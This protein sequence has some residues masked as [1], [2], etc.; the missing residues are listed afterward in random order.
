MPPKGRRL[1]TEKR[2]QSCRPAGAFHYRKQFEL[3][4]LDIDKEA[5]FYR[6]SSKNRQTQNNQISVILLM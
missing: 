6:F 2:S 5:F 1:N 3:N 4:T